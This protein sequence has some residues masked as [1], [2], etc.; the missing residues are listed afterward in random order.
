M[1]VAPSLGACGRGPLQRDIVV[2]TPDGYK[3]AA[4]V[5]GEGPKGVV[6]AH[7]ESSNKAFLAP[8]AY[9]LSRQGFVVATFNFR[10]YEGSEGVPDPATMDRDVVGAALALARNFGARDVTY[11]GFGTG[12]LVVARAATSQD[13]AP[14]ALALAGLPQ[15]YG[16]LEVSDVLPPLFLP[17]LFMVPSGDEALIAQIQQ[18]MNLAPNPKELHVYPA[19]E[20]WLDPQSAVRLP[21]SGVARLVRFLEA[22]ER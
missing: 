16:T 4:T 10:G 17:K 13:F 21:E 11:V 8:L 19:T 7:D 12:A 6:I 3:I 1:F 14:R 20:N 5:F 18:S 22:V 15:S 9:Y 2:V